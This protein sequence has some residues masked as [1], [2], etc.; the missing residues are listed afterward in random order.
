[1]PHTTVRVQAC[2]PVL[3]GYQTCLTSD[4]VRC[5]GY[6]RANTRAYRYHAPVCSW[7]FIEW[8]DVGENVNVSQLRIQ[9]PPT[10]F[11]ACLFSVRIPV[12]TPE[13]VCKHHTHRAT[14][15]YPHTGMQT[16]MWERCPRV[17][18]TWKWRFHNASRLT[19]LLIEQV[20]N[21]IRQLTVNRSIH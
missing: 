19:K 11:V 4:H 6:G 14:L 16:G 3:Y 15:I 12:C 21:F 20:C 2:I 5:S 17:N 18:S 9:A 10:Q 7:L 8:C 1:M 13:W